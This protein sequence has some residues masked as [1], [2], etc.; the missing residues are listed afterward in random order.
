MNV[1]IFQYWIYFFW[2]QGLF[3]SYSSHQIFDL[4]ITSC[5]RTYW[6]PIFIN[7]HRY[8]IFMWTLGLLTSEIEKGRWLRYIIINRALSLLIPIFIVVLETALSGNLISVLSIFSVS[9]LH[10]CNQ[11]CYTMTLTFII[12]IIIIIIFV[13]LKRNSLK[14]FRSIK[15]IFLLIYIAVE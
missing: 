2:Q 8:L 13:L 11:S 5:Q 9:V 4:L 10:R 15:L 7:R 1:V 6:G 12:I 14:G 3:R